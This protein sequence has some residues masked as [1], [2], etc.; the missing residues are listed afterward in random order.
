MKIRL[1]KI[2]DYEKIYDLWL[3]TKGMG[4][5][6]IDD[7]K[8]GIAKFL[9][10]N[11]TSNFVALDDDVIV[12]TI[13]CGHDGRRGHIYHTAV[14]ENSR[15]KGIGKA[16]I[17]A[18]FNALKMEGIIKVSL[19]AF[20]SNEIGNAFWQSQDFEKRTDLSYYNKVIINDK[21]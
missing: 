1:M 20:K 18:A 3:N 9:L 8:D 15:G 4:L 14:K 11:P 16:L 2:E 5:S 13:M 10:R 6:D 12:G 7:S 17:E 21:I 19:V